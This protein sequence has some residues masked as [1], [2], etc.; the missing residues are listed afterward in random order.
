MV[1]AEEPQ[2][3]NQLE[4]IIDEEGDQGALNQVRAMTFTALPR[5]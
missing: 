1:R 4:Q 3:T 5:K 2:L